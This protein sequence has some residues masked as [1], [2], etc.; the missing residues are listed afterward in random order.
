MASFDKMAAQ[1]DVLRDL[2]RVVQRLEA[3]AKMRDTLIAR[4]VHELHCP[5]SA[6]AS[7]ASLSK[8]RVQQVAAATPLPPEPPPYGHMEPRRHGPV[9]V[10]FGPPADE[11]AATALDEMVKTSGRRRRPS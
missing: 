9:A 11:A 7:A 8:S 1:V 4:L 3:D 5:M 2:Q 6:V 10:K